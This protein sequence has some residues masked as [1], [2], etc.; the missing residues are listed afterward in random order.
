MRGKRVCYLHGGK[1]LGAPQGNRYALKHGLYTR[2][3]IEQGRAVKR[4]IK[5]TEELLTE[6]C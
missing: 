5:D 4:L 2:E 3:A 1:S 6:I